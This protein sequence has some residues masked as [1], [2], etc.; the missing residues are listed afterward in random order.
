MQEGG[1]NVL[2][3]PTKGGGKGFGSPEG[4]RWTQIF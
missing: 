2:P 3:T 1:V 4:G